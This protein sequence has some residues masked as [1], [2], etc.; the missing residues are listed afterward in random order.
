[1]MSQQANTAVGIAA[2]SAIFQVTLYRTAHMGKLT[3]YLVVASGHEIYFQQTVMIRLTDEP[4]LQYGFLRMGHFVVVSIALVLL[5]ISYKPVGQCTFGLW[6]EVLCDCP[7]GLMH[8]AIT[9][10]LV[11]SCQCFRGFGKHNKSCHG[12]VKP[13]N[14]TEKHISRLL[15]LLLE[16]AF[17]I[18]RQWHIAGFVALHNLTTMLIDND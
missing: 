1:M 2:L 3:A 11:Q 12:S 9:K 13:M 10:H 14:H 4:V 7:I 6:R 5:F 18:F 15:I 17:D 8:F 16:I